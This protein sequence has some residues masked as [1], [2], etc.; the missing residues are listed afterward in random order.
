MKVHQF[1]WT[2]ET[3]PDATDSAD[4]LF[5]FWSLPEEEATAAL[6][7]LKAHFPNAI[8]AGCSTAGEIV[9]QSVHEKALVVTAISFDAAR[10]ECAKVRISQYQDSFAAGQDLARR[11][12]PEGL[13]H[14]LVFSDGMWVNGS[15]LTR[16]MTSTL[17]DGVSVTGGLA[18]DGENYERTLVAL[19]GPPEEGIVAAVG[20]YGESLSV[21]YGSRGGWDAF[22]PER[23]ITKSKDNVL[24]EMDGESALKLYELYLGKHAAGLPLT[25]LHFPLSIRQEGQTRKLVRTISSINREEQS[26]TFVGD[27]PE[28]AYA[29]LMKANFNRLVDGASDAGET[30]RPEDM[31]AEFALCIS[32]IGRKLVLKQMV[33]EELEA[34]SEA[35]GEQAVMTGFYSYGEI[36]P[37]VRGGTCE[38][39]NQTMTI[40]TLAETT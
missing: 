20:L 19:N 34:V 12:E 11:L 29:Q 30:A 36:A 24:Y 5:A 6:T 40:T 33:E 18:A 31:E 15:A 10:A 23:I 21:G 32:C 17:P 22:G 35:L 3:A 7:A 8:L 9:G 1:L 14:V 13:V 28:G 16:G 2:P 37:F 25:G 26:L 27:I 4:L 38:L 39:H